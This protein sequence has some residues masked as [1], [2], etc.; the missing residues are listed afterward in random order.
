MYLKILSAQRMDVWKLLSQNYHFGDANFK[1]VTAEL[2]W[3]ESE[4]ISEFSLANK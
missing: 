1:K 2:G 3:V 4:I